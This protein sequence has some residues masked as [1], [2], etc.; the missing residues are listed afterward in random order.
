MVPESPEVKAAVALSFIN[1]AAPDIKSK[2]QSI[3]SVEEKQMR[4]EK[5]RVKRDERE[6]AHRNQGAA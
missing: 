1:Q 5:G 2:L 6:E 3:E 4:A